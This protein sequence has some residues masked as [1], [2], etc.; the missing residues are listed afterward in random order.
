MSRIELKLSTYINHRTGASWYAITE[1]ECGSDLVEFEDINEA[2]SV[3]KAM[4]SEHQE[5]FWSLSV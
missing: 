4:V 2:R 3:L 5:Q 1:M